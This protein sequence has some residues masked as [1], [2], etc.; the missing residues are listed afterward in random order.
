MPQKYLKENQKGELE[1][2]L[3]FH[4]LSMNLPRKNTQ[5]GVFSKALLY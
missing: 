4:G 3:A 1:T 5:G 2:K